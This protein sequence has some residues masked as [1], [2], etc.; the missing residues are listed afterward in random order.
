[1]NAAVPPPLPVEKIPRVDKTLRRLFLTLFLRGRS[2]RGL[3]K[4]TAPKSIGQ[5]LAVTLGIYALFGCMA[6]AFARQPV[7]GLAVYLHAMT[8]V[9]LGMFVAASAG[10][11]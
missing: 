5:R 8:V 7:F 11:I 4:Q 3:N 2:S 9:F 10:E 6:L 1:M